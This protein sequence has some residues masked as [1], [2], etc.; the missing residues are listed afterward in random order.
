MLHAEKNPQKESMKIFGIW[1]NLDMGHPQGTQKE[2]K[3][4]SKSHQ[5]VAIWNIEKV[6]KGMVSMWASHE[7]PTAHG[8]ESICKLGKKRLTAV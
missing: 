8:T 6:R 3:Q 7:N 1:L 2:N 5:W 4:T